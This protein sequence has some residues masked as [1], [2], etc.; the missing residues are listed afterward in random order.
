MELLGKGILI[1]ILF[2]VT[3]LFAADLNSIDKLVD[4]INNTKDVK[5]KTQ[6]LNELDDEIATLDR[7]AVR[8]AQDLIDKK[9]KKPIFSEN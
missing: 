3:G 5:V 4:K 6:L 7:D 9:L 1:L 8:R 2:F